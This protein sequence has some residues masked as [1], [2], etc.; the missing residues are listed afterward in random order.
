[1][2]TSLSGLENITLMDNGFWLINNPL[3]TT[4]TDLNPALVI[5]TNEDSL[6]NI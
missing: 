3:I 1:M 4:L 6:T 2:L 5:N